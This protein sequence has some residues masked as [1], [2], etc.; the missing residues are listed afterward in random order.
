MSFST[1]QDKFERNQAD[2]SNQITSPF[3]SLCFTVR[4]IKSVI[5]KKIVLSKNKL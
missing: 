3:M 1:E 2:F 5:L 4:L